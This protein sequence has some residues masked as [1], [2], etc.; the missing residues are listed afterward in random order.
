MKTSE[1]LLALHHLGFNI[2]K[3]EEYLFDEL[4]AKYKELLAAKEADDKA[5]FRANLY[6]IKTVRRN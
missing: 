3:S 1:R 4:L 2:E 6:N 5:F